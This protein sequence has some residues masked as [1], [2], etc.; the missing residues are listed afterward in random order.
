[1]QEDALFPTQTPREALMFSA[2]LRLPKSY[3][4]AQRVAIVENIIAAL[5]LSKCADTLIG[6]ALVR[7]ISGGEKK[8][9]AIGVELVR[10]VLLPEPPSACAVVVCVT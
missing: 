4:Q 1:M 8:R 9:V 6:G 3:T 10:V 7:G 2:A 5:G